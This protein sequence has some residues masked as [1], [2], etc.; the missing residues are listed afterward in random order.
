[1]MQPE[2]GPRNTLVVIPT[3]NERANIGP[4]LR[5]L[6]A[7]EGRLHVL[8][9]DD[10]SPDGTGAEVAGLQ[11]RHR[12]RLH[13]LRRPGKGGLGSAY[14]AGFRWGLERDY[15]TLAQM[16][17]DFSHDPAALPDLV[18]GLERADVVVGSRYVGGKV[19]VVH[20]P[21]SRLALS[22]AANGY[23]R[24]VTGLPLSDSTGGFK[25]WKREVLESLGL[26]ALKS[27]GYSFQIEM[28]Y[29][30]HKKGYSL[31]EI[32]I[33]FNER[34]EGSSKMSAAIVREAVWRVWALRFG[35]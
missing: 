17:A 18:R 33:I 29:K 32:P 8:V 25:A 12:G 7:L 1:M 35:F 9:V 10:A 20:W 13:L 27:D 14:V 11:K 6:F 15:A 5:S 31:L 2:T 26:E 28:N 30:A 3:Y 19:S 4:L 21:L 16:D 24:M 34:T 23:V 22:M